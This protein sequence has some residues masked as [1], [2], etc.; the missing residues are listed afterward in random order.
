MRPTSEPAIC[1]QPVFEEEEP[2]GSPRDQCRRGELEWRPIVGPVETQADVTVHLGINVGKVPIYGEGPK[3]W[4]DCQNFRETAGALNEPEFD[5]V[6]IAQ[7]MR[8]NRLPPLEPTPLSRRT[9]SPLSE[10]EMPLERVQLRGQRQRLR[11][12][13]ICHGGYELWPRLLPRPE[14]RFEGLDANQ[15]PP[16][17]GYTSE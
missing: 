3:V 7:H 11:A 1:M 5:C 12:A 9:N 13:K 15:R 16:S 6:G 10:R 2:V 14:F 8:A 17:D 4:F